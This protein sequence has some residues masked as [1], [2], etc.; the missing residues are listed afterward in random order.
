MISEEYPSQEWLE[1]ESFLNEDEVGYV[2]HGGLV[3][4]DHVVDYCCRLANQ[5]GLEGMRFIDVWVSQAKEG[6]DPANVCARVFFKIAKKKEEI[7]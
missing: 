3:I 5:F 7:G 2:T 1:D 6:G 4:K